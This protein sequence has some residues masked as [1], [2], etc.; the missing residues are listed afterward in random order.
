MSCN[1]DK[2]LLYS[3]EDGTIEPLEKIFVEEHLKYCSECN[4]ELKI[5]KAIDSGLIG[6]SENTVF[7]EK[8][9]MIAEL[10]AE[11]CITQ[12]ENDESESKKYDY[13]AQI[14]ELNRAIFESQ[15]YGYN[16]PYN[17]FIRRSID[18]AFKTVEEPIK[19][20]CKKKVSML[21]I[22]KLLKVG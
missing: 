3:Y 5:I 6:I 13:I 7:P 19:N 2:K 11:N 10:V 15:K 9:S 12:I 21:N 8:L 18:S 1:M 22:L 16:N 14:M 4:K 20:Y 17:D